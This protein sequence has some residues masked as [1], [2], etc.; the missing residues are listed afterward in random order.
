MQEIL[1][2]VNW[3][4]L[5]FP[6]ESVATRGLSAIVRPLLPNGRKRPGRRVFEEFERCLFPRPMHKR[7]AVPAAGTGCMAAIEVERFLSH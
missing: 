2:T 5:G 4:S 6:S 1:P 7:Q 3:E